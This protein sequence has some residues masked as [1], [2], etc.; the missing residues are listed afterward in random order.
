MKHQEA[1]KMNKINDL[2][3][4][5]QL[6]KERVSNAKHGRDEI[7]QAKLRLGV[8][9]NLLNQPGLLSWPTARHMQCLSC[10]R[11]YYRVVWCFGCAQRYR[12]LD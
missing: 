7:E 1:E 10:T 3:T 2:F 9:S 12:W 8:D 5:L 6:E 4:E 11:T